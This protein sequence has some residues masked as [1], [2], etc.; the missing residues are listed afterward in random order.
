[1]EN[2]K[3]AAHKPPNCPLVYRHFDRILAFTES[4]TDCRY[5]GCNNQNRLV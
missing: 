1:M 2:F 4:V 3:S 5:A